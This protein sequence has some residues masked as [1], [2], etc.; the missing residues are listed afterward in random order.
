MSRPENFKQIFLIWDWDRDWNLKIWDRDF[1]LHNR[2]TDLQYER[3]KLHHY[4]KQQN[5]ISENEA[6][7]IIMQIVQALKYLNKLDKPVIHYDLK[8]GKS[9]TNIIYIE[10]IDLI[11]AKK[12]HKI[13]LW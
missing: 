12:N 7:T 13:Y 2:K 10:N 1:F 11:F 3:D 9:N 5:K 4:L 6:K 8:P